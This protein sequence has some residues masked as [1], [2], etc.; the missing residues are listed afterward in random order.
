MSEGECGAA[1]SLKKHFREGRFWSLRTLF[2]FFFFIALIQ[3]TACAHIVADGADGA[4][5]DIF[6]NSLDMDF[7][8]I[9]PGS[10]TMGAY[11]KEHTVKLSAPFYIGTH[12]VTQKQ[13]TAVMGYN[14]SAD[15]GDD[16]PVT[17]VTWGNIIKF[18]E[19]LN[20]FENST[21]YRLPTE[22]EWEYAARAGKR[23]KCFFFSNECIHSSELQDLYAW[24]GKRER[25]L[26]PIG[27]LRPNPWGLYDIYGNVS[28][29]VQ[30]SVARGGSYIDYY[31]SDCSSWYRNPT[32]I[33][34]AY[35]F[36]GFR[37]A[38]NS[39]PDG[40]GPASAA[41]RSGKKA[42]AALPTP[43]PAKG[44]F[45]WEWQKIPPK[46][47]LVSGNNRHYKVMPQKMN[48]HSANLECETLN[49][50]GVDD[51]HL[52]SEEDLRNAPGYH[53]YTEIGK[54]GIW[55]RNLSSD[56]R[57]ADYAKY[58]ENPNK[59]IIPSFERWNYAYLTREYNFICSTA[60]TVN[61]ESLAAY[62]A[63]AELAERCVPFGE[64]APEREAAVALSKGEF[65]ST[66]D[67]NKRQLA[68]EAETKKLHQHRLAE[69]LARK[70]KWEEDCAQFK[71]NLTDPAYNVKY[72]EKA[73]YSLNGYPL[74]AG[75]MYNAD[76]QVFDLTIR[77]SN[78]SS[79]PD[80]S[81]LSDD[82]HFSIPVKA[83]YAKEYK[84]FIENTPLT[85]ARFGNKEIGKSAFIPALRVDLDNG[86]YTFSLESA[87]LREPIQTLDFL[88]YSQA[89]GN[90]DKLQVFISGKPS[91][92]KSEAETE[93]AQL[94]A[95][96]SRQAKITEEARKQ[97]A[98]DQEKRAQEQ[99]E[100]ERRRLLSYSSEKRIGDEVCRDMIFL[101][102]FDDV[103]SG[104]VEQVSGDRIQVRITRGGNE[105]I[106][107]DYYKWRRCKF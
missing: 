97:W 73:F 14:P 16:K 81:S 42:E 96:A 29:L 15:K 107:D 58:N 62:L 28:E 21:S 94:K 19:F 8:R 51:W 20:R 37:L 66:A 89:K 74:L 12:E 38:M 3:T 53:L 71:R 88:H 100:Y 27:Q 95:E 18:I 59:N 31:G 78:N 2:L 55:M 64:K 49:Y 79:L 9:E 76:R 43:L 104:Y 86:T 7:V 36:M 35:D 93:L 70:K 50:L 52:P 4:D 63:S 90:M 105:V 24:C 83:S 30:E 44:F 23:G 33:N 10:F 45:V 67:F 48:W 17:N 34:T 54:I 26:H 103:H 56:R 11:G 85:P 98:I 106:W 68:Y 82:L 6:R 87:E 5:R 101:F 99:A 46:T 84:E 102:L 41:E 92:Y 60:S 47:G 13:W 72:Y 25:F 39:T 91:F 40:V 1:G 22:E 65:E 61:L 77:K 69:Y 80:N 57:E 32:D 75:I